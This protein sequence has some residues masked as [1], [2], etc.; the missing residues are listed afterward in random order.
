MSPRKSSTSSA[1]PL[2]RPRYLGVEVAGVRPLAPRWLERELAR[3]LAGA[4]GGPVD[5]RLIR[6]GTRRALVRV[7]N[8]TMIAARRAWNGALTGPT[9]APVDVATRRTFGTLRKGKAWL[10]DEGAGTLSRGERP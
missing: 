9:G 4:E 10:K 5:I 7:T 8:R 2:P 6:A 1:E 3:T